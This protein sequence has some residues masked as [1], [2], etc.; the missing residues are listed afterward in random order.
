MA[1]SSSIGCCYL[2]LTICIWTNGVAPVN[3]L[4]EDILDVI[5]LG[6]EVT[7]SL[8]ETWDIIEQTHHGNEVDIP[9]Y[10]IKEKKILA[11]MSELSRQIQLVE[12]EVSGALL[13]KIYSSAFIPN[14]SQIQTSSQVTW[15]IDKIT[16]N[17]ITNTQLRLQL[18]ELRNFID[19]VS[20]QYSRM[21]T[22][23]EHEDLENNTLISYAEWTVSP[24]DNAIRGLLD[25]LHLLIAGNQDLKAVGSNGLLEMIA[26]NLQVRKKFSCI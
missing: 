13:H 22:F 18:E 1:R 4:V 3:A 20:T 14:Y 17:M 6:K 10:K 2:L 12:S 16:Q 26:N 24:S 21:K 25:R 11:R 15:T 23:S 8:L 9:F 5:K 7:T 19:R